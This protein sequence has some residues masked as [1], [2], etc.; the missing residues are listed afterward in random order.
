MSG[1]NYNSDDYELNHGLP[2]DTYSKQYGSFVI[3]AV[4]SLLAFVFV[5][6]LF[7]SHTYY[8]LGNTTS[9]ETHKAEVIT[10]MAPYPKG[11]LPF[12]KGIIDSLKTAFFHGNQLRDWELPDPNSPQVHKFF[13]LCMNRYWSC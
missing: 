3:T 2:K 1:L 13:N 4:I 9:W 12:Y 6:L 10:Y 7:L 8:V 5:F 11:Y